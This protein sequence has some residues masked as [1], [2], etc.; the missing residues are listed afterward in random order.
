MF[1]VALFFSGKKLSSIELANHSSEVVKKNVRKAYRGQGALGSFRFAPMVSTVE[2]YLGK[3]GLRDNWDSFLG[4]VLWKK[5]WGR[6]RERGWNAWAG[7]FTVGRDEVE[8]RACVRRRMIRESIC[9]WISLCC[10]P[11]WA[12]TSLKVNNKK[13]VLTDFVL[14]NSGYFYFTSKIVLRV[15]YIVG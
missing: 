14:V 11:W 6:E 12:V 5:G 7:K 4:P 8:L 3:R 2:M 15:I 1:E 13:H 10:S 9:Y